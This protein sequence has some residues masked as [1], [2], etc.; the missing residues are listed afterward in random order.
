[1]AKR[2]PDE[3]TFYCQNDLVNCVNDVTGLE[4]GLVSN[5]WPKDPKTNNQAAI[6]WSK[7]RYANQNNNNILKSRVYTLPN[8]TIHDVKIV[9]ISYRSQN[10][11]CFKALVHDKFLVDMT[12]ESLMDVISN[13]EIKD[14][15]IKS[16]MIFGVAK[17][18]SLI[19]EGGKF[20]DNIIFNDLKNIKPKDLKPFHIYEDLDN[21]F[22]YFGNIEEFN[23][24]YNRPLEFNHTTRKYDYGV[25]TI[26]KRSS[27]SNV[28]F[29]IEKKKGLKV[30]L[31][32]LDYYNRMGL[33]YNY[34]VSKFIAKKEL[35]PFNDLFD[36]FL[37]Q[38]ENFD[39]KKQ[40]FASHSFGYVLTIIKA[41][42]YSPKSKMAKEWL[43]WMDEIPSEGNYE[44]EML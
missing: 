25:A 9:D 1:M 31:Y 41:L 39:W 20:H 22:L 11:K 4:Y 3:I 6:T 21:Y 18:L 30:K 16:P 14:G 33:L 24:F 40:T 10:G 32:S 27:I 36:T 42:N 44:R 12:P 19:M 17:K 38:F 15:V 23:F 7:N 43:D 8:K 34:S 26:N 35:R 5:S 29:R 28:C 2:I 13:G 37:E